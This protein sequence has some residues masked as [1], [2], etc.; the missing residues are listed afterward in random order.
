[1]FGYLEAQFAKVVVMIQFTF[2]LFLFV[3]YICLDF[4]VCLIV[5]QYQKQS[6]IEKYWLI[7]K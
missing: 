5:K 3:I 6:I 7:W 4:Q 1:M 2:V